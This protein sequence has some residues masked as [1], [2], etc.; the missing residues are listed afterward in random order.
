MYSATISIFVELITDYILYRE[1]IWLLMSIWVKTFTAFAPK[2]EKMDFEIRTT[3]TT[4]LLV[5]TTSLRASQWNRPVVCFN[6]HSYLTYCWIGDKPYNIGTILGLIMWFVI[7]LLLLQHF[8]H[9]LFRHQTICICV[10]ICLVSSL[11]HK[12]FS[13][14]SPNMAET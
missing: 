9:K 3:K 6:N 12:R 8:R 11:L 7:F 14:C 13:I 5:W 1:K 4:D 10:Y 2:K